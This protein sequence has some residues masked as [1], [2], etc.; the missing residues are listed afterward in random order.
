MSEGKVSQWFRQIKDDQTNMHDEN[1]SGHT[2]VMHDDLVEKVN[3]K[4]RE[5]W[6]FPISELSMCFL[7]ISHILLYETVSERLHYHKVC[8]R[9]IPKMLTDKHK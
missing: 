2:S 6:Q 5:N 9:W 3:N 1:R 4:I 8:A 7:Q